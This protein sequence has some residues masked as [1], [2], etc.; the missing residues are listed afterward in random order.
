MK[1]IFFSFFVIALSSC[2]VKKYQTIPY[3]I[4][5][6]KDSVN[7]ESSMLTPLLRIQKSDAFTMDVSSQNSMAS[8]LFDNGSAV[9]SNS[10]ESGATSLK[11]YIVDSEGNIRI[12]L[13]GSIQIE[14]LSLIEAR[15]K[16]ENQLKIYLKEPVVNLKLTNFRISILGDVARPGAYFANNENINVVEAITLA[17]DLN[18]TAQRNNILLVRQNEGKREYI[19]MDI[20]SKNIFSSPYFYLKSGDVLYVQPGPAKYESIDNK[21]RNFSAILSV[22][23]VLTII[24]A[25]FIR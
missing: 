13:A 8:A 2:G 1:Y 3:F 21:Y 23:S 18:I 22:I 9:G 16:I 7:S 11:S 5:L 17:G 4:D 25:Q 20:Q 14:G 15:L 12:P 24:Y 6:P 10:G 19:R